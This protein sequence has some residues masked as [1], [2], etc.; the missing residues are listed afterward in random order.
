MTTK[1]EPKRRG[2]PPKV[3]QTVLEEMKDA[4]NADI[5]A[6]AAA[7]VEVRDQRMELTR[8]ETACK[9]ELMNAM[10]AASET[11]YETEDGLI[12]E[13]THDEREDVKVRRPKPEKEE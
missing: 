8:Q 1:S 2:R 5:E 13:I 7:Y 4:Y 10:K 3:K 12:V 9:V 11:T 6:K